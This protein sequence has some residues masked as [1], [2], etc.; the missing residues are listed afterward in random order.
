MKMRVVREAIVFILGC[1]LIWYLF[2][3]LEDIGAYG[4]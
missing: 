3:V 2:E 1:T 4:L